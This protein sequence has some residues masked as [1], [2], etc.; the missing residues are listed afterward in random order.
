MLYGGIKPTLIRIHKIRKKYRGLLEKH[1]R[2]LS[3]T[4]KHVLVADERVVRVL[5]IPWKDVVLVESEKIV[6]VASTVVQNNA[7]TVD[8]RSKRK[9]IFDDK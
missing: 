6:Q 1:L 5:R 2:V 4:M 3:W 7:K 9:S 8:R